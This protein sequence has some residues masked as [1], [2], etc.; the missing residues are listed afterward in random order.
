M[1]LDLVLDHV[2]VVVPDLA[3]AAASFTRLGFRL[4][5]ESS[6]KGAVTPGGPVETWGSGNRCAMFRE[7]YLEI[8]GIT[9]PRR[10]TARVTPLLE[11]YAGLHLI[12]LGCADAD[13]AAAVFGDRLGA[14]ITCRD[15]GRDVPFGD[16]TRPA[17][18]RILDLPPGT[19]PDAELFL[20]EQATPEVLW[21][22]AQLEHPN[23]A[24]ALAGVV[25]CSAEPGRTRDRLDRVLG[26]VPLARGTIE[27]VDPTELASRY[28][29]FRPPA[30]PFVAAARFLA[31]T[32]A[33][34]GGLVEGGFVDFVA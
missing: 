24:I 23:N 9:D 29:G 14:R 30:L 21:Q 20:I 18:F 27:I 28:D 26:G 10:Y 2:A 8:L 1:S 31:P 13:A 19:F 6:H 32:G 16:G 22:P 11:R 4:T 25:I 17:R 33:Q 12:A 15:V 34:R 3:R 7:G 5:R